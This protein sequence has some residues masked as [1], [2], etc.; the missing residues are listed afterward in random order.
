MSAL[1]EVKMPGKFF[2]LTLF[3]L[4]R[5]KNIYMMLL[6]TVNTGMLNKVHYQHYGVYYLF[7][8]GL[9][10]WLS[11]KEPTCQCRRHRG[12]PGLI[13]GSGRSPGE[14]N[15][16]PLQYSCLG[17]PMDKGSWWATVHELQ[18]AGHNLAS[19]NKHDLFFIDKFRIWNL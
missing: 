18:R 10:W 8:Y 3:L 1:Y 2:I 14:G 16:N 4:V 6:T 7:L 9:P 5:G 12:D 11:G 15:G 13:P 19:D 17:N